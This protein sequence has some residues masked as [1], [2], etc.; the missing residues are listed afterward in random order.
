M[1]FGISLLQH[2]VMMF[3]VT[4]LQCPYPVV[5]MLPASII[6]KEDA[7]GTKEMLPLQ[8]TVITACVLHPPGC[9]PLFTSMV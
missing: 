3:P 6:P 7:D 4:T 8:K 1:V 9:G 5:L 2:P